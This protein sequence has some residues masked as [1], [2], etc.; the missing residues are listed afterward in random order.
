MMIVTSGAVAFGKLKL[1]SELSMQQTMR[2]SLR[3]NGRRGV[4]LKH[5]FSVQLI[6]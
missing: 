1:R 5:F 2:D 6:L 3:L 4:S